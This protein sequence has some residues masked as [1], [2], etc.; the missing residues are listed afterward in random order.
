MEYFR[1]FEL[2]S[3]ILSYAPYPVSRQLKDKDLRTLIYKVV[4]ETK[5]VTTL[6]ETLEQNANIFT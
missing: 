3:M 6:E 2:P 4:S 5:E 1:G